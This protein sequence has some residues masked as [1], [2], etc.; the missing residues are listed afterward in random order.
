MTSGKR[1]VADVMLI[2]CLSHICNCNHL[3]YILLLKWMAVTTEI[4]TC[5][6]SHLKYRQSQHKLQT[7]VTVTWTQIT[8]LYLWLDHLFIQQ[9]VGHRSIRE[10]VSD[11]FTII[12]YL[13]RRIR[14][15]EI[16]NASVGVLCARSHDISD[17]GKPSHGLLKHLKT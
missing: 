5:S 17:E 6:D 2:Y 15:Q 11:I 12:L 1:Q 4:N 8:V 9:W 14:T 10:D 3:V 16:I 13:H 7:P